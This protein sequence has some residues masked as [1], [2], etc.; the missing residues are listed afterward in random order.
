MTDKIGGDVKTTMTMRWPLLALLATA[1]GTVGLAISVA[2]AERPSAPSLEPKPNEHPLAPVLRWAQQGLPAIEKLKDYSAVLV[3]RE[4]IRDRLTGYEY[5]FIKVRHQPFSVY[6]LFQAPAAVKGQEVIYVAGRNQGDL[7]AHKAR[8]PVTV[9]LRPDG[10]LA[11]NG[12]HY[13]LTE[14]G[15]VNLVQRLVEVGKQDLN[16][17]E[18]EVKY[19]AD[20]KVDQRRCTVIQVVHP[21]RRDEFRFHLADICRRRASGA[22]P[23][24][25]ARLAPRAGRPARVDRGIHLPRSEV[26]QRVHRRGFQHAESGVSLR[27]SARRV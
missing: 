11:M 25:V 3:R 23:L 24:R 22:D 8:M 7:L 10:L 16:H 21:V 5:V 18:C 14:I 26:E 12:R 9:S 15:L 1:A 19:F 2:L 13:P 17:G 20:A 27:A 6:A 4:R